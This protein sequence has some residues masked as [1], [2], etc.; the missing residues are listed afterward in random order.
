MVAVRAMWERAVSEVK[1]ERPEAKPRTYDLD[2]ARLA[3]DLESGMVGVERWG[4][5]SEG[6]GRGSAVSRIPRLLTGC[7]AGREARLPVIHLQL[8]FAWSARQDAGH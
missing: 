6:Y 3:H 1:A 2:A 4:G 8:K 7:W 5:S